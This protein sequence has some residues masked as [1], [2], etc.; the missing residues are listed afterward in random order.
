MPMLSK[1][2]SDFSFFR[3]IFLAWTMDKK[4]CDFYI[5]AQL[6]NKD[7]KALV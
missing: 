1:N 4:E 3:C 2:G 6:M 7:W 5:I